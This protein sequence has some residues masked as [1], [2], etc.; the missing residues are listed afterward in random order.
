[1]TGSDQAYRVNVRNG[2]AKFS[3]TPFRL[4]PGRGYDVRIT[5]LD[6]T[7][8]DEI[9]L[10]FLHRTILEFA[11]SRVHVWQ[12]IQLMNMG[13]EQYVFP[14]EGHL[15]RLPSGWTA[16]QSQPVMS[17]Q[18][19]EAVEGE[20]VY[21]RGSLPPG[22]TNLVYGFDLPLSGSEMTI[23]VPISFRTYQYRV[24]SDAAKGMELFVEGSSNVEFPE[25]ETQSLNGR[26]M[27][28]TAIERGPDDSQ[29]RSVRIEVSN[30]PG[31]PSVRYFALGGAAVLI[32][33]ALIFLITRG[34]GHAPLGKRL[35]QRSK[36]QLIDEAIEVESAFAADEIG[37]KYRERRMAN[38]LERLASVLRDESTAGAATDLPDRLEELRRKRNKPKARVGEAALYLGAGFLL[39]GIF[40]MVAFHLANDDLKEIKAGRLS[41]EKAGALKFVRGAGF[42]FSALWLVQVVVLSIL[43]VREAM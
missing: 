11:D 19:L 4:P 23:D 37:P 20:G 27:L 43:F 26:R 2:G 6:T 31:A 1:A 25:A 13:R 30:I 10:Q 42:A 9:L 5:Q 22:R 24:E 28:V 18:R 3:S 38:I 41:D 34:E 21:L 14:D 33:L 16:F 8:R 15:I 35:R 7:D 17:D 12:Q 29:L 39:C 40:H 32:I 36:D